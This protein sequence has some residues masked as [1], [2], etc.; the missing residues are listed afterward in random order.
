ME[1]SGNNFTNKNNSI[2]IEKVGGNIRPEILFEKIKTNTENNSDIKKSPFLYL[3]QIA[4]SSR[5]KKNNNINLK[6][7]ENISDSDLLSSNSNSLYIDSDIKKDE[8]T[9]QDIDNIMKQ[10]VEKNDNT[11]LSGDTNLFEFLISKYLNIEKNNIK[12][13]KEFEFKIDLQLDE[14][15][16]LNEYGLKMP[17]LIS[18]NLSNSILKNISNIGISF[19]NLKILNVT[20]CQIDEIEGIS[21]INN[22]KKIYLYST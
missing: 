7:N 13:V 19:K 2:L 8:F 11:F 21:F 5:K 14:Y 22:I 1:I 4:T 6:N 18:L 17:N 9:P 12:N 3:L 16:F 10:I 20:N 15:N